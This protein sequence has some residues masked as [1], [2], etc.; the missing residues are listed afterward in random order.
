MSG[1]KER[2]V[3]HSMAEFQAMNAAKKPMPDG[4]DSA[5]ALG[6]I[7]WATTEQATAGVAAATAPR[8]STLSRAR[9]LP[10]HFGYGGQAVGLGDEQAALRQIVRLER[11]SA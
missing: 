8:P 5:D 7:E 1:K 9:Q 4:A 3:R 11:E 10:E 2:T 6:P